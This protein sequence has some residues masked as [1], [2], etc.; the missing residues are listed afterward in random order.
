MSRP[1]R[2]WVT[3]ADLRAAEEQEAARKNA[4]HIAISGFMEL[5]I[6]SGYLQIPAPGQH[7]PI[8]E[9]YS[10]WHKDPAGKWQRSIGVPVN[11]QMASITDFERELTRCLAGLEA[12]FSV[13]VAAG[14]TVFFHPVK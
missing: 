4:Y 12:P 13:R 6:T 3:C 10:G 7:L 1:K 8:S 9:D 14:W 2:P 5:V 11:Y